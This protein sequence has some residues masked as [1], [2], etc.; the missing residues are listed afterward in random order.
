V[1]AEELENTKTIKVSV[2]EDVYGYDH[3]IEVKDEDCKEC[4]R[5]LKSANLWF[6]QEDGVVGLCS[7]CLIESYGE[8]NIRE[9]T[10]NCAE[11]N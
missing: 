9:C 2:D 7:E 5:C 1:K 6:P 10:G 11:S 3:L 8:S 4:E